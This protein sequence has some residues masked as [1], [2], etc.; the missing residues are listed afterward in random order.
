MQS[1]LGGCVKIICLV[2]AIGFVYA[3]SSP[4]VQQVDGQMISSRQYI[5]GK[6]AVTTSGMNISVEIEQGLDLLDEQLDLPYDDQF[7]F[8]SE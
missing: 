1:K 2:V 3:F 4:A 8:S 6:E 5:T 7:K